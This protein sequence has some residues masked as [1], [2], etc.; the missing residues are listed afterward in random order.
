[1]T[2]EQRTQRVRE[3]ARK[4]PPLIDRKLHHGRPTGVTRFSRPPARRATSTR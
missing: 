4:L 1:M 3:A 2:I